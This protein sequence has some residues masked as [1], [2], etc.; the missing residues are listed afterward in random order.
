MIVFDAESLSQVQ[1]AKALFEL[2]QQIPIVN[3]S[4]RGA[5]RPRIEL[6]ARD[7]RYRLFDHQEPF[8]QRGLQAAV[9]NGARQTL[10]AP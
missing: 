8:S 4:R 6:S 3:R 9:K 7:E 10:G 5:S 1:P 2:C